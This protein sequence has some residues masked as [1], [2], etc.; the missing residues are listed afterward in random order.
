MIVQLT[1]DEGSPI[2]DNRLTVEM[3]EEDDGND[4]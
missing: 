2:D 1:E 4:C 3:M